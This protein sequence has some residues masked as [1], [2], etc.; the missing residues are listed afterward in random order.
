MTRRAFVGPGACGAIVL[1][2]MFGGI[3]RGAAKGAD[4]TA[5]T[6]G[7]PS[8]APAAGDDKLQSEFLLDVV[9]ERGQSNNV[10]SPGGN[11][12]VVPVLGG[13][14][15]AATGSSYVRTD[16]V[17]STCAFYCRPTMPRRFT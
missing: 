16:R 17:S 6:Q 10:G 7:A 15:A 9:F 4:S 12:I 11:R 8:L 2:L 5:T 14:F 13:T 1:A 3:S